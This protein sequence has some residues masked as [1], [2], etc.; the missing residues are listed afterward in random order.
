MRPIDRHLTPTDTC[1]T[2][3]HVHLS[4]LGVFPERIH[5]TGGGSAS[6]DVLQVYADVFGV[7][8]WRL[9]GGAAAGAALRALVSCYCSCSFSVL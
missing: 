8:V 2:I 3:E 6:V 4:K 1:I 9:K 5:A 7:D